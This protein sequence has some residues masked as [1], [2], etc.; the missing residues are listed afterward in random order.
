MVAHLG[1]HRGDEED[2][3]EN[4]VFDFDD[5]LNTDEIEKR[6]SSG[7]TPGGIKDEVDEDGDFE[8]DHILMI[9]K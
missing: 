2:F 9:L 3:D 4:D 6:Q 5:D 7:G 8:F 1:V